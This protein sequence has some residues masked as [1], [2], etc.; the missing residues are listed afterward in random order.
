MGP[1]RRRTLPA[2]ADITPCPDICVDL[3]QR[4]RYHST[5]RF[6]KLLSQYDV[7]ATFFLLDR[8]LADNAS[9]VQE[10]AAAGHDLAVHGWDHMA[11]VARVIRANNRKDIL[12]STTS[13]G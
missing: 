11:S 2:L 6:L 10:M 8:R 9:L 1:L 5:P 7:T 13:S 4:T 12:L 3:Q